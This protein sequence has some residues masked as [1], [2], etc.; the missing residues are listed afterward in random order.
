MRHRVLGRR[1]AAITG[2]M[3]AFQGALG[4][5]RL[6]AADEDATRPNI[7][8]AIADDWSF[9][10]A[11][12]YDCEWVET[13]AF[14]RVAREGVLFSNAF[15][16]NP[17]C[18]PCRAS[19]LTGRNSWQLEEATNHFGLFPHKWPVYPEVLEAAGYHVGFTGKGW[20]PGDYEAG[21]FDR[22]PAGPAYQR[23]RARPPHGGIANTDYAANF[24]DFLKQKPDDAPFCFWYGGHEPH[25]GYEEGAGVREGK[26]PKAVDLPKF[27]PDNNTIRSDMLDY[28][29]EV[30]WFDTHLGRI[31]GAAR[32]GRRSWTTR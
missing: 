32:K 7:L 1:L 17:K 4:G 13:P 11:G 16:S 2:I 9:G 20:G 18:S 26:D 15:T 24:A 12:A 3:I 27:Y 14:D 28:A 29:V 21:G 22:N 30:E 8:I 25:R 31:L 6:D 10:H 5:G 19:L 23:H